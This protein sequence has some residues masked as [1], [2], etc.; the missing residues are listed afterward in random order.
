[1]TSNLDNNNLNASDKFNI[2]IEPIHTLKN[3]YPLH[4]A[5]KLVCF[6][7]NCSPKDITENVDEPRKA[8]KYLTVLDIM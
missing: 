3:K 6:T 2:L 4:V 8:L 7:L 1:M 5:A